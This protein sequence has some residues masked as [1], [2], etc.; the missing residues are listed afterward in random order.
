MDQGVDKELI[1][2]HDMRLVMPRGTS[3]RRA[4]EAW[5]QARD[6]LSALIRAEF[7]DDAAQI[8]NRTNLY[9]PLQLMRLVENR[10]EAM[11]VFRRLQT[12]PSLGHTGGVTASTNLGRFAEGLYGD[13]ATTF[14]QNYEST[15]GRLF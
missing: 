5:Q 10:D 7:G 4:L 12:V 11:A 14:I 13:G 3:D 15:S 6:D 8:L 2:D 9:P 1:S